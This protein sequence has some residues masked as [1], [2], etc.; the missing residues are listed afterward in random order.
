[1]EENSIYEY[2]QENVAPNGKICPDC[3]MKE[4][5]SRVYNREYEA[6]IYNSF[7]KLSMWDVNVDNSIE[8]VEFKIYPVVERLLDSLDSSEIEKYF[9]D[10][11]Y[12]LY[13]YLFI[14]SFIY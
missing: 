5:I 1:M 13:V 3:T 11:E 10:K 8:K 14:I 12:A 6:D 9:K 2:I 4:Y 7:C